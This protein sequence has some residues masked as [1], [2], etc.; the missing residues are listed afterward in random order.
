[1]KPTLKEILLTQDMGEEYAD[2]VCD[3]VLNNSFDVS[4]DLISAIIVKAFEENDYS[5]YDSMETDLRY[6]I[7]QL[8]KARLCIKG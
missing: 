2:K 5:D 8:E 6:A 3:S 7:N 4:K 1:M